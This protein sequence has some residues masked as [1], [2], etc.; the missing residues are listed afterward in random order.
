MLASLAAT[1]LCLFHAPHFSLYAR[2]LIV[3]AV[4]RH[5]FTDGLEFVSYEAGAFLFGLCLLYL[6]DGFF[7]QLAGVGYYACRFGFGVGDEFVAFG[8]NFGCRG[9]VLLY[10]LVGSF[11]CYAY[12]VALALPVT[13]VAG[14][15]P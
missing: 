14:Y 10:E 12:A 5:V 4:V 1:F 15:F 9:L 2:C 3:A 11:L 6:T 8:E 7:Y 13:F